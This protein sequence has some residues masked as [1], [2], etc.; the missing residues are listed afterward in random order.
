[1]PY[2]DPEKNREYIRKWQQ[3]NADKVNAKNR[4]YRAAH[5]EQ[6]NK[7]TQNWRAN[8]RERNR[9]NQR[10]WY[11]EHPEKARIWSHNQRALRAGV[12]STLTESQEKE[13]LEKGCLFCGTHDDLTIAHDTPVI[14][15]GNTTRGNCF[16]LC[17]ACNSKMHTKS[18][19]EILKQLL[20]P[21]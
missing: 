19:K 16:C 2:K 18:L 1:M 15:G 21:F 12:L 13:I 20:F 11:K 10:Q 14:K 9:H 6:S 4:A 7:F 3:D 17:R 8:N 5:P